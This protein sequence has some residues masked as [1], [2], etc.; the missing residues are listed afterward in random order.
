MIG[1]IIGRRT[2]ALGLAVPGALAW[3]GG[4]LF[5]GAYSQDLGVMGGMVMAIPVKYSATAIL[6]C[7]LSGGVYAPLRPGARTDPKDRSGS[8]SGGC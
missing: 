5:T 6:M 2:A 7:L 3:I 4:E 1:L 8:R